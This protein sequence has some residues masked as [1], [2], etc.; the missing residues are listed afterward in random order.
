MS[1]GDTLAMLQEIFFIVHF[2]IFKLNLSL[3]LSTFRLFL[4]NIIRVWIIK[5]EKEK[6]LVIYIYKSYKIITVNYVGKL[7]S[8]T[9]TP[10]SWE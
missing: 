10:T 9:E 4:H 3:S 7:L 8:C 6:A 1:L 2:F 5:K